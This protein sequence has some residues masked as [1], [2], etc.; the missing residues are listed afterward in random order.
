[1][2][3]KNRIYQFENGLVLLYEEMNWSESFAIGISVPCGVIWEPSELAG[4]AAMTCE[5][6]NRGAGEYDNRSFL[7]EFENIGVRSSE[8][9][10]K[11][12][13]HFGARGLCDNWERTLELLALQVCK[14]QLIEDELAVCKQICIQEITAEND[15]PDNKTNRAF[16]DIFLPNP[17]GRR[18]IGTVESIEKMTVDDLRRYHQAVY[19]PNGTVIGVAGRVPWEKLRDKVD[20]LFGDWNV[21]DAR[22][23]QLE[24]NK[25]STVHIP[26]NNAQAIIKL[27]YRDISSRTPD[28]LRSLG[29][30]KVLSGGMSSRLFTEVREKRGLCYSVDASHYSI[31]DIGYVVCSCG[32]TVERAQ[33]SLDVILAEIE[34]LGTD[35][36]SQS[37]LERVKIRLKSSLIMQRESA[38]RRVGAI[39]GDWLDFRKI[40]QLDELSGKIESLTCEAI[41]SYY[42]ENSDTRKFRLATL[43]PRPL[44]IP[45]DKLF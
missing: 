18:T 15:N 12:Y 10:A 26:S 24:E 37:E 5:M 22:R 28:Y 44:E 4:L 25:Q 13:S 21:K 11:I 39:I 41:E 2:D 36:I 8:V 40:Q 29:G 27:G 16:Y 14:P 9:T 19:R 7:E 32:T 31:E 34:R 43:G 30:I 35:P 17:L 23:A 33:E 42:A 6:T 3:E 20:Q 45:K 38:S 1:M